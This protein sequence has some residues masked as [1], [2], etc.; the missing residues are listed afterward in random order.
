MHRVGKY[1]LGTDVSQIDVKL[2]E[3]QKIVTALLE[4]NLQPVL[5]QR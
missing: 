4:R 1:Y 3:Y 5:I 2:A